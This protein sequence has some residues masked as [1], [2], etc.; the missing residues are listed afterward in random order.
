MVNIFPRR[1]FLIILVLEPSLLHL[2]TD[3]LVLELLS[4]LNELLDM[5]PIIYN[6]IVF[7]VQTQPLLLDDI[8][9][10]S[11][12]YLP[13]PEQNLLQLGVRNYRQQDVHTQHEHVYEERTHLD[14]HPLLGMPE[15]IVAAVEVVQRVEVVVVQVLHVHQRHYRVQ[16]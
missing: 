14:V 6:L 12:S 4:L 15:R 8:S 2:F 7:K 1:R 5:N 3:H 11:S 9:N 16:K 13:P 10:H